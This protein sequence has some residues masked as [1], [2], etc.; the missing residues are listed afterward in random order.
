[1]LQAITDS[2][3]ASTLQSVHVLE[4]NSNSRTDFQAGNAFEV[5][6]ACQE[7]PCS[8]WDLTML[9]YQAGTAEE[10]ETMKRTPKRTRSS[11]PLQINVSETK[12]VRKCYRSFE[13][14]LKSPNTD[15]SYYDSEAEITVPSR[16]LRFMDSPSLE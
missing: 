7:A 13:Q 14:P 11:G 2:P 3:S 1:M 15:G 12:P 10:I 6:V 4:Q 5:Q 9:L 16:T 8:Q